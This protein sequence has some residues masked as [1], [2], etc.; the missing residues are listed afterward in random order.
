[1]YP[2]PTIHLFSLFCKILLG[3]RSPGTSIKS[4][5][6]L[7]QPKTASW[8]VTNRGESLE[9]NMLLELSPGGGIVD[10]WYVS[11]L[12]FSLVFKFFCY[13]HI[14]FI[15]RKYSKCL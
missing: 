1:M 5:F 12:Y 7:S 15:M 4:P 3:V 9:E 10:D 6:L 2:D 13:D 8:G 11:F 14:T